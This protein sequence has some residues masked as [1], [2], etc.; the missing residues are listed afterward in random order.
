MLV[1]SLKWVFWPLE[2]TVLRA[3]VLIT[4]LKN[5]GKTDIKIPDHQTR[6]WTIAHEN[7][8]K[9]GIYLLWDSFDLEN[10][11][12]W[13]SR[14]TCSITKFL[15]DVH[16]KIMAKKMSKC[17]SP[18]VHGLWHTK[19]GKMGGGLYLLRGSFDLQN[20]SKKPWWPTVCIDNVLTDVHE[21]I[22]HFW[23]RNP[24]HP[25]NGAHENRQN[26]AYARFGARLTFQMAQ[27]SRDGQ[28][29]A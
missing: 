28:P 5:S 18:K 24:D 8:Q 23:R 9:W 14:R 29:Y 6:W 13:S 20:G 21:Q 26:E 19:I 1:W 4:S 27:K 2:S 11:L 22:W 3:K 17:G 16:K 7:L 25:K 10:G 12:F 15:M